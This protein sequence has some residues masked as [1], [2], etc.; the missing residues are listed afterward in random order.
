M[1]DGKLGQCSQRNKCKVYKEFTG[2][3][4]SPRSIEF[5]VPFA[6][7]CVSLLIRQTRPSSDGQP[8]PIA[9]NSAS[10][11]VFPH[12][13]THKWLHCIRMFHLKMNF[14]A[15]DIDRRGCAGFRRRGRTKPCID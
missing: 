11:F 14:L 9:L 4:D 7:S 6:A 1:R 2:R 3:D 10:F 5:F 15:T 12:R 13:S 8:C